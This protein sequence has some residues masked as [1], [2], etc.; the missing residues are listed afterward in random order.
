MTTIAVKRSFFD[1]VIGEPIALAISQPHQALISSASI[2]LVASEAGLL[3]GWPANWMLAIG[4]E[5]A[6]LK[7]LTSGQA[8][9]TPWASRLNWAAVLLVILY[10]SLW[11]LRRFGVPLPAEG[12]AATDL[13]SIVGASVLTAIHILSIGAVTLCSAMVHR[14][15]LDAEHADR[16]AADLRERERAERLQAQQDELHAEMA[17]KTAE[18]EM[19]ERAQRVKAALKGSAPTRAPAERPTC[20]TCGQQLDSQ[21]FALY[22]SAQTRQARFRGCKTC[23]SA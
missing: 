21:D 11:G 9:K 13:W 19:W 1:A 3:V 10:G 12:F 14:A 22:K 5:W 17:R 16:A 8:V 2:Y 15:A 23:R 18:L 4:A 6:Y 7:G 20:P